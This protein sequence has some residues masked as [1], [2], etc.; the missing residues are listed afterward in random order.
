M[1]KAL[2][3]QAAFKTWLE[4]QFAKGRTSQR[5]AIDAVL[6][7]RLSPVE[8]RIANLEAIRERNAETRERRAVIASREYGTDDPDF[9]GLT[10]QYQLE[11]HIVGH[12]NGW[13]TK[14]TRE[15]PE[16]RI[17]HE[18]VEKTQSV[19]V[20]TAGGF[21]VPA[22]YMAEMMVPA[23][24]D[25]TVLGAL[26][27]TI[28]DDLE[29]VSGADFSRV[30]GTSDAYWLGEIQDIPDTEMSFERVEMRPH[31]LN[32]IIPASNR[33]LRVNAGAIGMFTREL[34]EQLGEKL[35]AT[36]LVGGGAQAVPIGVLNQKG[37][38]GINCAGLEFGSTTDIQ[39]VSDK[40]DEFV[41]ALED[42]HAYRGRLGWVIAPKVRRQIRKVKTTD[43]KPVFFETMAPAGNMAN[44]TLGP[45]R[46]ELANHPYATRLPYEAGSA[47]DD[48]IIFGNWSDLIVGIFKRMTIEVNTQAG[49]AWRSNKTLIK[50]TLEADFGIR[51][52][53]S[54]AVGNDF[55]V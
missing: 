28:L 6:T 53:Q 25:Q 18:G 15:W 14:S 24:R 30:D 19:G 26:G 49:T 8:A 43:G 37:V 33:L 55:P 31:G 5:E 41:G 50:A 45:I 23:L 54:F 9:L 35:D 29:G 46:G 47:V 32:A 48:L 21:T 42:R 12:M 34:Q 17:H 39:D 16:Y 38:T 13:S 11:R 4:G 20:D 2:I 51:R 44:G 36:G 22:F 1:T 10:A 52:P 3:D 7:E 27:A 40:L